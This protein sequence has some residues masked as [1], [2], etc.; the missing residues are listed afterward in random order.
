MIIYSLSW[1]RDLSKL[2]EL[3][4]NPIE[5]INKV[6]SKQNKWNWPNCYMAHGPLDYK[7]DYEK[8]LVGFD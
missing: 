1:D 5:F 3:N 6:C 8:K 4:P 2:S 7:A